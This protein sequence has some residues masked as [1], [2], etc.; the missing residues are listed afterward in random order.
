MRRSAKVFISRVS[1]NQD[2]PPYG[3]APAAL[4]NSAVF[5]VCLFL[6]QPAVPT[7]PNSGQRH[8]DQRAQA[9]NDVGWADGKE[10]SRLGVLAKAGARHGRGGGPF[11][12]HR[13]DPL[14]NSAAKLIGPDLRLR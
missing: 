14:A 7:R 10:A 8:R 3:F 4:N 9:L 11:V 1:E 13:H 6:G 12:P 2:T 5:A